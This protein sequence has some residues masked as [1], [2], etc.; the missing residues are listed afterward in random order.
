MNLA[1][2]SMVSLAVV[3]GAISIWWIGQTLKEGRKAVKDSK[4]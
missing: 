2:S 3:I 1:Q 4:R